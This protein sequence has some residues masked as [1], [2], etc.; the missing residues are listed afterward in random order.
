MTEQRIKAATDP[1]LEHKIDVVRRILQ[2]GLI[3]LGAG[4][5]LRAAI[6]PFDRM[7]E[8]AQLPHTKSPATQIEIIVPAKEDEKENAP[9]NA[10]EDT[11]S[12]WRM[13]PKFAQQTASPPSW[14]DKHFVRPYIMEPIARQ[15]PDTGASD[16]LFTPVGLTAAGA[17]ATAGLV[18]G[19][20][21]VKWILERHRRAE[22]LQELEEAK[23]QYRDALAARLD[24]TKSAAGDATLDDAYDQYRRLKTAG[25]WQNI[26]DYLNYGGGIVGLGMLG[27][28]GLSAWA[29]YKWLKNRS[30]RRAQEE[31]LRWYERLNPPTSPIQAIA[32]RD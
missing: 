6:E 23:Q 32:V 26:I 11:S 14:L 1:M 3:G 8:A 19:W 15:L 29:T 5:A 17:T 31:M 21:L 7:H 10:P 13:L 4:G 25:I 24:M 27:A 2:M 12:R 22:K 9:A 28:G 30:R 20:N 18:G 16:L